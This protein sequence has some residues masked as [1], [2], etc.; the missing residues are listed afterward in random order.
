MSD[1]MKRIAD[2]SPEKQ[3]L[4]LAQLNKKQGKT[5]Q[6]Q[7]QKRDTSLLPLSVGQERLWFLQQLDSNSTAY[8][9]SL[10]MRVQ[11]PFQ[12]AALEQS[13]QKLLQRH[14]VLRTTFTEQEGRPFQV[15][16]PSSYTIRVPVIDLRELPFSVREQTLQQLVQ[17][18]ANALFDLLHGPLLRVSVLRLDAQEQVLLLSMHHIISDGWSLG[19]LVRELSTLYDAEVA[20]Q[21]A[22]LPALPIQYADYALWQRSWLAGDTLEQHLDYWRTRLAG[23][24]ALLA[25]PTDRPRPAVQT[26]V[27]ARQSLLLP[28]ALLNQLTALSQR[29]GA[30]LFYDSAG[31]LPGVAAA[32]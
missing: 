22:Q 29:E 25:L 16:A 31:S 6:I 5:L 13:V 12:L 9:M 2:L 4:L 8:T 11:G 18:E 30:T 21:A 3:R 15:I 1:L 32:L 17:Q 28:P 20:Q 14:E 7:P 19:I 10:A 27:G 26:F 23:A 24:P